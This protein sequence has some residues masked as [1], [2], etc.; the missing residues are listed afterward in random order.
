VRYAGLSNHPIDLMT[1]A[2]A[3]APITSNQHQY[4]LLQRT[5]EADV[6]P[7]SARHG[8]GFLAWSPLASGFLT[9]AF[10][11]D[12]L[13]PQDF[14]RRHPYAEPSRY[15]RL[16]ALKRILRT[17][18]DDHQKTLVDLAIAW[19]LRQPAVTGVIVGI[20]NAREASA[21]V[22]GTSWRLTADELATIE[23]ALGGWDE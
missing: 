6:L 13:D 7:Y 18:A 16:T 22:G 17:I 1:R 15:A 2:M 9:D 10:D 12:A 3:L 4:N 23:Q 8:I 19:A 5:V 21:M 11:L 20:R 14:R